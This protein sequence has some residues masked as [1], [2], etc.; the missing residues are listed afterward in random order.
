MD[1]EE[2]LSTRDSKKKRGEDEVNRDIASATEVR[3]HVV[4]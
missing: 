4:E 2:Q 1:A 3:V